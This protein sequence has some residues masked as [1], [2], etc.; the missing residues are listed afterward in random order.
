MFLV[1][2]TPANTN[3]V[4]RE[5]KISSGARIAHCTDHSRV[6]SLYGFVLQKRLSWK[7]WIKDFCKKTFWDKIILNIFKPLEHFV[8]QKKIKIASDTLNAAIQWTETTPNSRVLNIVK[9]YGISRLYFLIC[10]TLKLL[11]CC[12]SFINFNWIKYEIYFSCINNSG[13]EI[14]KSG[15]KAIIFNQVRVYVTQISGIKTKFSSSLV[16]PKNG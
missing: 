5:Y 14:I 12:T 1:L 7:R 3:D 11:C 4:C 9:C 6:M 15:P 10:E 13:D 2:L 8:L 16:V